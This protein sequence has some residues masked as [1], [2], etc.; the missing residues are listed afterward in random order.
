MTGLAEHFVLLASGMDTNSVTGTQLMTRPI[1]LSI[2]GRNVLAALDRRGFKHILLPMANEKPYVDKEGSG[3]RLEHRVL[4]TGGENVRYLDIV[5]QIPELG[6]VFEHLCEDI[7]QRLEDDPS[8][9]QETANRVLEEW[10]ELLKS[11]SGLTRELVLGLTGEL[12]VLSILAACDPLGAVRAWRGPEGALHDFALGGRQLEVKTTSSTDGNYVEI[13]HMDQLDPSIAPGLHLCVVHVREDDAG[14]DLDDRID[15]LL[16][17]GVP[18]RRLLDLVTKAGYLF[19]SGRSE[20]YSV[21]SVR[22]WIVDDAFPGLRRSEI[23][24]SRLKGVSG[25]RYQ[26]ALDTASASLSN[27]SSEEY[28]RRWFQ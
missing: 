7:V 1:R 18:R 14:P 19:E 25:V 23:A 13:T 22:I 6:L 2:G 26:L 11:A 20:R 4:S 12:E 3:V 5:C 27:R 15:D 10:R 21:R 17:K 28:W 24:P 9:P 8:R 16:M